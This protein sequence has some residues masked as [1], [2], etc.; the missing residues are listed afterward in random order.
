MGK[1]GTRPSR[2]LNTL[3]DGFSYVLP[4]CACRPLVDPEFTDYL[5]QIGAQGELIVVD[6]SP[7]HVYAEH[8]RIWGRYGTHVVPDGETP[9][10]KVTGV[11]TGLRLA[12]HERVVIAD[13]DVRYGSEIADLVGRLDQADVVRPQN[14]FAPLPWHAVWDSGRSLLNRMGR[15]DW[16]GTLGVRRSALPG[17]YAGNVM[18]ENYELVKTV[19]AG[20]GRQLV[21]ADLFVRRVPP[22]TGHFFRQRVRQAYDEFARP[23]RLAA[24]LPVVPTLVVLA[25]IG[26]WAAIRRAAVALVVATIGAA[27]MGR[28]RDGARDWFPAGCSLAA[29]VWVL[30][31]SLC[32]WAA[33]FARARGGVV[34]RGRRIKHAAASPR[35]RSQRAA[36]DRGRNQ[37]GLAETSASGTAWS[38][39]SNR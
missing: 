38:P 35:E 32:V 31:R 5:A 2:P 28:R 24:F 23:G 11:M 19:E 39:G 16:P 30:E 9:V 18:F 6:G 13:D 17:G 29:P 7:P 25:V 36:G 33:L 15:G 8:D 26:R 34:Y 21:A 20:G 14:F 37:V 10:G 3:A 12:A 4:L 27:E 22:T 1:P